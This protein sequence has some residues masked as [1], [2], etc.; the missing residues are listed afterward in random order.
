M[1]ILNTAIDSSM[2]CDDFETTVN[3]D[4][5]SVEE[6]VGQGAAAYEIS[7]KMSE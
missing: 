6:I 7:K 1:Y 5:A 2:Y 4:S 3:I